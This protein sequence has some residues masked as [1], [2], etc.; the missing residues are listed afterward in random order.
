MVEGGSGEASL[1]ASIVHLRCSP[2]ECRSKSIPVRDFFAGETGL[3]SST[4]LSVGT[5]DGKL[6]V[7]WQAG[8]RGGLRMRL[9]EADSIASTPDVIV[10]DDLMQSGRIIDG[11]TILDAKLLRSDRFAVL[12]LVTPSGLRALRV[13]GDGKMTPVKL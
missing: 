5:V 7:V 6:L 13:T 2:T 12:L 8:L 9:A 10:Y 4:P 11:S 3:A 1:D